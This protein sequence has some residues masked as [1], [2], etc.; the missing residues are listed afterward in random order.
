MTEKNYKLNVTSVEITDPEDFSYSF[1][2]TGVVT[3]VSDSSTIGTISNDK[4]FFEQVSSTQTMK[5]YGETKTIYHGQTIF[6]IN[7]TGFVFPIWELVSTV[8]DN[9]QKI[10]IGRITLLITFLDTASN[11]SNS[12][13]LRIVTSNKTNSASTA[14]LVNSTSL[15]TATAD[16][17]ETN[18]NLGKKNFYIQGRSAVATATTSNTTSTSDVIKYTVDFNNYLTSQTNGNYFTIGLETGS[19]VASGLIK[20]ESYVEVIS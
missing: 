16:S 13:L 5:E 6:K 1:S 19:S 4:Y 7:S 9:I 3:K 14:S 2:S 17:I 15:G 8:T 12:D 11:A 20:I 18:S 10:N